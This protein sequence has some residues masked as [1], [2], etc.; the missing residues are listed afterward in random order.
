M[1]AAGA[2]G[3]GGVNEMIAGPSLIPRGARLVQ[4][5]RALGPFFIPGGESAFADQKL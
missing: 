4:V 2:Q 3:F 5:L 1:S